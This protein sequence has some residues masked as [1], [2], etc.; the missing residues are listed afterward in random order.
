MSEKFAHEGLAFPFFFYIFLIYFCLFYYLLSLLF[1]NKPS[2]S[3][4]FSLSG[5]TPIAF[6]VGVPKRGKRWEFAG[7]VGKEE[8]MLDLLFSSIYIPIPLL[9]ILIW[10]VYTFVDARR[11]PESGWPFFFLFL[12]SSLSFF[13]SFFIFGELTHFWKQ[14][15]RGKVVVL[16]GASSG[17][18]RELALQYAKQGAK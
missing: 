8:E 9:F 18:G 15:A 3:F 6:F 17:I 2:S 16:S 13:F 10:A 14:I 4:V 11:V 7:F 12:L 1:L 5:S